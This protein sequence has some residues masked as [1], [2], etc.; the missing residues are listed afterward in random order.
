MLR[1]STNQVRYALDEVDKASES[2]L[3]LALKTAE[4]L[5]A[6]SELVRLEIEAHLLSIRRSQ[7]GTH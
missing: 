5:V 1:Y 3:V 7:P 4:M 6:K 2:D